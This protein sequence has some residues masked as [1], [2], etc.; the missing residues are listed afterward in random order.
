[1]NNLKR[2]LLSENST[3]HDV[4]VRLNEGISGIACIVNDEE[5]LVGIFT[6]GDIRRTILGGAELSAPAR[7]FMNRN[8]IFGTSKMDRKFILSLLNERVRHLPIL[9]ENGCPVEIITWADIW[10]MPLVEPSLGGNEIKYVTDCIRTN[11]ISSQGAFVERFER[12]FANYHEMPYAVSCSSG[13]TALHLGLLALGIGTGDEVIIPDLTFGASINAVIHTGATPVM[14][15]IDPQSWNL[16]PHLVEKAITSR[17][18][19]IMTVHLYGLP[20]DMD[21]LKATAKKYNLSIIE[22]CAESLGA[23]FKGRK[24]GT[25][26]DVSTFSFFANKTITTG[27]GGMILTKNRDFAHRMRL[28]RDHG[29]NPKKRYWHEEVGFNYRI[30]NIQSALGCAQ[31]EQVNRFIKTRQ[32]LARIYQDG[33]DEFPWL[34]PQA[35]FDDRSSSHWLYTLLVSDDAP[36][37]REEITKGLADEGIDTRPIFHSLHQQPAFSKFK[38]DPCPVSADISSRGF[39]LPTSNHMTAADA[40]RVVITFKKLLDRKQFLLK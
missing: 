5:V 13:T 3:L 27:E 17:T 2:H 37:D 7:E 10:K 28:L 12:E 30:T 34:L 6:D 1:M 14:V 25:L 29:M 40:E 39:S 36:I 11:W 8:F 33:F 35:S 9:N 4:L 32:D 20:C 23:E 38:T 15:D 16:D 21:C 19:A 18:K 24:M 26:G 31:L 22:D